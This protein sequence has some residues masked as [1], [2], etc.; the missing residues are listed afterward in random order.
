[1]RKVPS[2]GR[3]PREADFRLVYRAGSRRT[4]EVLVIHVLPTRGHDVRLGLA[5][6]RRFGRAVVR[7][8]LRRRIREA[9]RAHRPR[10]RVGCDL[11]VSPRNRT[12][13]ASFAEL[14]S[15]VDEVLSAAGVLAD[16]RDP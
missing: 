3:L 5:V 4:T 15:A 2:I 1:M 11:V 13:T 6:G 9:V 10:I 7:N 14:L 16:R 8:R 12:V